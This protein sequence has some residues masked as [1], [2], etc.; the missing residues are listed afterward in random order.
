MKAI[1]LTQVYE[2]YAWNEDGS[3]GT[4]ADAY[5]KPKGGDEYVVRNIDSETVFDILE[6][7]A[8]Q[9]EKSNDY[10]QEFIVDV[11]IVEDDYLTEYELNQLEFDGVITYPAKEL[12]MEFA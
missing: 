11:K 3:I 1:I 6:K 7:V 4:G 2:N 10:Y 5:F 9:I 12:E 8:G